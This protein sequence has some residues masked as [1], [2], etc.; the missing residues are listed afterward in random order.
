MF[1]LSQMLW[2]WER[3]GILASYQE[4]SENGDSTEVLSWSQIARISR[5]L[6]VSK[7]TEEL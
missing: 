6:F 3:R 7:F 2:E 1:C 5:L 4:N